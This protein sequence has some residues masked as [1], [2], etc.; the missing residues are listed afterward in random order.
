LSRLLGADRIEGE[1]FRVAYIFLLFYCNFI[2]FKHYSDELKTVDW[3][4]W[5]I[6]ETDVSVTKLFGF[7][8]SA[9]H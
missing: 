7:G 3:F 4:A 1:A 2:N 5:E 6:E 9:T 8:V